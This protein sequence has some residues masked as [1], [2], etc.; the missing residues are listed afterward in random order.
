VAAPWAA[1]R[2]SALATASNPLTIASWAA[3]FAA[4]STARFSAEPSGTVL[5]L[6]GILVGSLTWF[7]LLS[8]GM[9]LVGRRLGDRGLRWADGAAGLGMIGY[10]GL[11]GLRTLHHS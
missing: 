10:G 8:V 3:I 7:S 6:A 5:L 2:T 4:A 11:L 1:F 9:R